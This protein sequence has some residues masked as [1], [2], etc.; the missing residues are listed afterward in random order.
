VC[1]LLERAMDAG[2]LRRM[3][4]LVGARML[5]ALF[6]THALWHHQ[7]TSFKSIAHVPVDVI[8]DQLRDFFLHAMRP[9][10]PA[11]PPFA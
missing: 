7:R 9:D 11:V 1:G 5:S 6:V 2:V 10:A 8:F 3:D 4:P